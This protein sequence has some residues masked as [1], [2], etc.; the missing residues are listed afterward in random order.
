[1]LDN[2]FTYEINHFHSLTILLPSDFTLEYPNSLQENLPCEISN[3]SNLVAFIVQHTPCNTDSRYPKNEV[4]FR[5]NVTTND[6]WRH[7]FLASCKSKNNASLNH[8][9]IY[10]I[11]ESNITLEEGNLWTAG[12]PS[13][14]NCGQIFVK[15]SG[16][17]GTHSGLS[18]RHCFGVTSLFKVAYDTLNPA[19]KARLGSLERSKTIRCPLAIDF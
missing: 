15:T 13:R 3:H 2:I 6:C 17:H 1:M 18:M 8:L 19:I 4:K 5:K 11:F 9:S 7:W 10:Y 14:Y 12:N 16:W